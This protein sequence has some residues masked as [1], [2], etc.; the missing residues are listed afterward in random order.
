MKAKCKTKWHGKKIETKMEDATYKSL[1]HAVRSIRIIARRSIRKRKKPSSAGSP[2]HTQ[3]NQL[4]QAIVY[5]VDR[6]K[7]YAI[8]GPSKDL[9]SLAGAAHEHGGLFRGRKYPKRGYM[10]PAMEKAIPRLPKQWAASF[11]G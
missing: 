7:F 1:G 11:K 6:R 2:P 9:I 10:K 5:F 8:V 4:K 3:T